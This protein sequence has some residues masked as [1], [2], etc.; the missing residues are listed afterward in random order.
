M[1]TPEERSESGQHRGLTEGQ[2]R[3]R[4]FTKYKNSRLYERGTGRKY[5]G[6]NQLVPLILRGE[7]FRVVDKATKLDVTHKTLGS[8]LVWGKLHDSE[9]MAVIRMMENMNG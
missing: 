5:M 1:R 6:L 8:L 2:S 7:E 3:C 9:R 4:I